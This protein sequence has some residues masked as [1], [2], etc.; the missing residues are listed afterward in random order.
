MDT[1][2][3]VQHRLRSSWADSRRGPAQA[4]H[5][6]ELAAPTVP[7]R[8]HRRV[9]PEPAKRFA[10]S[11]LA[12]PFESIGLSGAATTP[13]QSLRVPLHPGKIQVQAKSGLA[14]WQQIV[15]AAYI[16]KHIAESITVRALARFV[17]LSSDC[18]R[19]AFKRSFGVPPNR[20]LVQQRIE[21]AK[22]LLA[23]SAWSIAEIGLALGFS[24]S[25]SF[26]AAFRK[27][28]GTTPTEYRLS[29]QRL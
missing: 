7:P 26:S 8:R 17:Y 13:H 21:R 20:Y 11:S 27:I 18:F 29:Q 25:S 12:P 23:A 28:T 5:R 6:S 3:Q 22:A 24:G 14:V 19:R 10:F 15:I 2:N 9:S 4:T 1:S 16:E